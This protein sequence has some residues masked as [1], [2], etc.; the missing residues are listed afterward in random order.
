MNSSDLAF[1]LVGNLVQTALESVEVTLG[2]I[3]FWV[4]E[5][6]E[7]LDVGDFEISQFRGDLL[8]K[9]AE[10]PTDPIR[11]GVGAGLELPELGFLHI[12]RPAIKRTLEPGF[13]NIVPVGG[14]CVQHSV[15]ADGLLGSGGQESVQVALRPDSGEATGAKPAAGNDQFFVKTMAPRSRQDQPSMA[16]QPDVA[17]VEGSRPGRH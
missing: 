14:Q 9:V 2:L 1:D 16:D 3:P 11:L 4:G 8:P 13:C 10:N 15:L 6:A 12:L 17:G 7:L 5:Q